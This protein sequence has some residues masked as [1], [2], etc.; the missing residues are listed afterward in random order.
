MANPNPPSESKTPVFDGK[1]AAIMGAVFLAVFALF[2]IL[3]AMDRAHRDRLEMIQP[4][5]QK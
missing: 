5:A 4:A 1:F 2:A 3:G